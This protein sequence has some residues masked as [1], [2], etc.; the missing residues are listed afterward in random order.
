MCVQHNTSMSFVDNNVDCQKEAKT[1]LDPSSRFDAIPACNRWTDE[2]TDMDGRTHG[3][4]I[5]R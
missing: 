1:E 5:D 3:D 4:R 2:W